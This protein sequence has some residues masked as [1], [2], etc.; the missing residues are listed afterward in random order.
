MSLFNN[1]VT[2]DQILNY[3]NWDL[4]LSE[5]ISMENDKYPISIEKAL[6]NKILYFEEEFNSYLNFKK[7][8]LLYSSLNEQRETFSKFSNQLTPLSDEEYY[9]LDNYNY[10]NLCHQFNKLLIEGK[11]YKLN[12]L[13]NYIIPVVEFGLNHSIGMYNMIGAPDYDYIIEEISEEALQIFHNNIYSAMRLVY[14]TSH[15]LNY[16]ESKSKLIFKSAEEEDMIQN[17]KIVFKGTTAQFAY[18]IDLLIGKDYIKL[19]SIKGQPKARFLLKHFDIENSKG[20]PS[21]S[22]LGKLFSSE[23]DSIKNEEHKILFQKMPNRNVLDK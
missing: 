13:K 20:G 3:F 1:N 15:F 14:V 21:V 18:I 9:F 17:D 6:K 10:Y 19:N 2:L 5:L 23:E 22:S 7:K 4:T 8:E 16:L 12:Y 11:N